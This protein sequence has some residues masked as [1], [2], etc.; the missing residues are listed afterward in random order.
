MDGALAAAQERQ[1]DLIKPLLERPAAAEGVDWAALVAAQ[2]RQ[3]ELLERLAEHVAAP[4][5]DP[6]DGPALA[7]A[8][9]AAVDGAL[10]AAQERQ[11]ETLAQLIEHVAAAADPIDGPVLVAALGDAVDR[12]MASAQDRQTETLA[13][14]IERLVIRLE[15]ARPDPMASA[16]AGPMAPRPV[17]RSGQIVEAL[18]ELRVENEELP[19]L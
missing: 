2:E 9:G 12:A 4:A 16:E 3:A 11:T 17:P 19:V 15:A 7:A 14:L 13:R 6:I 10:A 5:A 1:T 8:L 18:E